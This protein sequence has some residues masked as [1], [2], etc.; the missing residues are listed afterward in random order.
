[1]KLRHVTKSDFPLLVEKYINVFS[2]EPW[3]ETHDTDK[4]KE[5]IQN[6]YSMNTFLGFIAEEE[7]SE[8][9][10]GVSLGF[11][12]PWFSGKE[13]VLDTFFIDYQ[14]QS[15]GLGS[16]FLKLLKKELREIS[17]PVIMLDTDKG[18][19][20]EKFYIKNGFESS[21]SSILMFSDTE[22]E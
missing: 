14:Y 19:P 12:K 6:I 17:I 4:I 9:F 22:K 21:K 16:S 13:Y 10:V 2:K 11:I 8:K 3:N 5:Y 1:M 18:M 20:S 7:V 15:L